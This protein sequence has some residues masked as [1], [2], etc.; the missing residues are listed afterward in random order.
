MT[1]EQRQALV[2]AACKAR[3]R[4]YAP[5]SKFRVGAAILTQ[6][7]V[8]HVGC[9]VES[10]SYGLTVCAERVA[11]CNAVASGEREFE[12]LAIA[13]NDGSPPCGAC[14]QFAVEFADNLTVLLV[15]TRNAQGPREFTLR[16]LLPES[17]TFPH[18][19]SK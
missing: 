11:I 13:T 10:A 1:D 2:D 18:G 8:I 12:A 7:G 3:E 17:F 9:N 16:E 6:S 15:N 19:K 14:R 5:Y 4:A